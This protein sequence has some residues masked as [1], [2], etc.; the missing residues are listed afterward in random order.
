MKTQTRI[1]IKNQDT[2]EEQVFLNQGSYKLPWKLDRVET[3]RVPGEPGEPETEAI[4]ARRAKLAVWTTKLGLPIHEFFDL[5][6]WMLKKDCPYCQMGTQV[7][8]AI[9]EL[10]EAKAEKALG[11]I[12]Q[13]KK[14]DDHA[15]LERIKK[16]LWPSEQPT[17]QA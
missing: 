13:A 17:S 16:N 3:I 15:R 11:E 10:G 2:G 6:R 8:K 1:I 7:L 4:L 14:D 12:L 5:A 9:D